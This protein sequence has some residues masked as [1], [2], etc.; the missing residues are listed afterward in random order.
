M[1]FNLVRKEAISLFILFSMPELS[2][3][4]EAVISSANTSWIMTSTALVLFMTL[5]GLAMEGWCGLKTY[6]PC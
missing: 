3:A 6:Y 1:S 2:M 5:P 4:E